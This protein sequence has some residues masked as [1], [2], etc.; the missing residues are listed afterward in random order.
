[1]HVEVSVAWEP[2]V[3][4]ASSVL[5]PLISK[6]FLAG[7]WTSCGFFFSEAD[8]SVSGCTVSRAG[9]G[10]T[11]DAAGFDKAGEAAAEG[12]GG[13]DKAGG[14][15]GCACCC[16]AGSPY[17]IPTYPANTALAPKINTSSASERRF[18][19]SLLKLP[20]AECEPRADI[21][22]IVAARQGAD[23]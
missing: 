9:I 22:S 21:S 14:I 4:A 20:D 3:L 2:V 7:G 5:G 17:F 12:R 1:L 15:A 10:G 23:E 19:V 13:A 18:T 16:E 8:C 11:A 6:A